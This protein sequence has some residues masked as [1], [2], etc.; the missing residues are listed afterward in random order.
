[1]DEN[2]KL[3]IHYQ[4]TNSF[5][6]I[7]VSGVHGGAA[8]NKDLIFMNIFMDRVPIPQKMHVEISSEGRI[9]NPDPNDIEGKKGVIREVE[10]CLVLDKSTAI[11]IRTWLDDKIKALSR[12]EIG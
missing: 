8:S 1:M 3:E 12:P 9:D 10:A 4:K 6:N 7:Y 11:E 2:K 5:R